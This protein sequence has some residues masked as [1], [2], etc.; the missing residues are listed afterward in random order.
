MRLV[1]GPLPAG[2]YWKRRAMVLGGLVLAVLIVTYSCTTAAQTVDPKAAKT[3]THSP[4]ATV[5]PS[6]QGIVGVQDFS[7]SPTPPPVADGACTDADLKIS[8]APAKTTMAQGTEIIIRL[9]IKNISNRT[10]TRDIG[11]DPQEVRIVLGTEKLWSSD[12][13]GGPTT[14][15]DVKTFTPNLERS[16]ETLWNGHT[17]VSCSPTQKRTPT[18]PTPSAGEYQLIGRVGTDLSEPLTIKIT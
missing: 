18:G 1:V 17:S 11:P 6:P 15:S 7:S 5:S 10:C 16:F 2:V 9:L 13:C 8:V 3:P 14:G 4:I 12:D